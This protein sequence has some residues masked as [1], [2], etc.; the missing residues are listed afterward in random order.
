MRQEAE[1][2]RRSFLLL[3]AALHRRAALPGVKVAGRVTGHLRAM[4]TTNNK[5]EFHCYK[6]RP[7]QAGRIPSRAKR[8][9]NV[10]VNVLHRG[11]SAE[12]L[13]NIADNNS[14]NLTVKS[15]RFA[16]SDDNKNYSVSFSN[17]NNELAGCEFV[18]TS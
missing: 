6:C 14:L 15:T 4:P 12:D 10:S 11:N 5:Y 16:V 7:S 1:S 13:Q 3:S 2:N 9:E 18:V 17:V 8:N